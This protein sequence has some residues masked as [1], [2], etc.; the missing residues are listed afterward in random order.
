M[1][2]TAG[3]TDKYTDIRI[4]VKVRGRHVEIPA[5]RTLQVCRVVSAA[6]PGSRAT[7]RPRPTVTVNLIRYHG[8]SAR[9]PPI[10]PARPSPQP[11]FDYAA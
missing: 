2:G 11:E 4:H 1:R 8:L 5:Q 7:G 3:R 6:L 9:P 10:A